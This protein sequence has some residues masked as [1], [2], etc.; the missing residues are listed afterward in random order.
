MG[1]CAGK[2]QPGKLNKLNN[3]NP[4]R[5]GTRIRSAD[6]SSNVRNSGEK[7]IKRSIEK[8]SL[9]QSIDKNSRTK[10]N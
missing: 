5:T 3:N 6:K 7:S 2:H 8:N 10:S 9:N 4:L 1:Q